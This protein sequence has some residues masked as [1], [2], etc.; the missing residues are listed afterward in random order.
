MIVKGKYNKAKVFSEDLDAGSF[1]QIQKLC[2]Q[3]F[4]KD[5]QI[6]IMPD[7]HVGKG[8]TIGTTMTITDKVVPN[9][10]GVDIGC[11]L[12]VVKIKNRVIDY[13][14][15][16]RVIK[17]YIPS[18]FSIRKKKHHNTQEIDLERLRC[19][20]SVDLERGY[21]SMGTLGGGNHFIEVNEGDDYQKYLV[22]HSGS[23]H[24]GLQVA[25]FY[26]DKAQAY[27]KKHNIKVDSDL[28][29]LE[30]S[31]MQDYLHDMSI[32]QEFARLNRKTMADIIISEMKWVDISAFQ[33]IHN[34]IDIEHK[35]LRKGAVSAME[36]ELFILPLNMR[37][38]SY[39]LRGKGNADWNFSSPH[40]AGRRLSRTQ[41]KRNLKLSDYQSS[42]SEVYSSMISHHTLDE[43]PMAYK[44]GEIILEQIKPTAN[45]V[46]KLKVLYNFKSK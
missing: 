33:T 46:E 19:S 10:V 23:R 29:Y 6:R 30:G 3:S 24:I 18:G 25:S 42:M 22:I 21:L 20:Q 11:G 14:K 9:L 43:A 4:L 27:S 35:I 17:E 16:D 40:G 5:S 37:D 44:D 1:Q 41:A 31:L 13:R 34:Y 36:D 7:V 8:A 38:G 26:Q 12:I 2:N 32:I 39:L 28:A 45:V 15:L